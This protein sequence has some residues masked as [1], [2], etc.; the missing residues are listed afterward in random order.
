MSKPTNCKARQ[1]SDQ[2]LCEC[3]LGWDMNDPEP[4]T[5]RKGVV[6]KQELAAMRETLAEPGFWALKK[7]RLFILSEMPLRWLPTCNI[8]AGLYQ[9]NWAS[10]AEAVFVLIEMPLGQSPGRDYRFFDTQGRPHLEVR[11]RDGA[12]GREFSYRYDG[13]A[14]LAE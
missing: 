9:V 7:K 12:N 8:S 2:M 6:A 4:P 11:R 1:H 10:M 3:G 14:W 13:G 5:C